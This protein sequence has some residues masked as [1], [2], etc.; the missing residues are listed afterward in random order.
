MAHKS[1]FTAPGAQSRAHSRS[2]WQNPQA[3]V[4][5]F[6]CTTQVHKAGYRSRGPKPQ[7]HKAGSAKQCP[8]SRVHKAGSP[9]QVPQSGLYE[10]VAIKQDPQNGLHAKIFTGSTKLGPR[11]LFCFPPCLC[12]RP[13]RSNAS[14]DWSGGALPPQPKTRGVPQPKPK[15]LRKMENR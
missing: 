4:H 8:Q 9:R 13:P 10:A 7:I 5:N 11:S 14:D 15:I 3:Q 6:R 2:T 1:R 12:P